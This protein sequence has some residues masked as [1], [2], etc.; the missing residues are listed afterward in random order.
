MVLGDAHNMSLK[1][2]CVCVW[3]CVCVGGWVE[4]V[5]LKKVGNET[6]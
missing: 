6:C 3:V 1:V 5:S 4:S 2:V